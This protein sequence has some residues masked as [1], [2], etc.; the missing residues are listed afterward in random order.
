MSDANDTYGRLIRT[1]KEIALLGST[2]SVLHWDQETHLPTKGHE[3]RSNQVSLIAR[4]T[5]EQFTSP[6]VGEMLATA[7]SARMMD[8]DATV[9][10]RELRRL[11]DRATKIPAT[12]VEELSKTGVLAHQA[13]IEARKNS[14][15]PTFKPWLA[16][17]L[18]LKRQEAK[19]VGYKTAPYDALLDEFEPHETTENLKHVFES[20]RGPLVELV[21]KITS[22]G[23]TA[24]LEILERK[25]PAAA[26]EAV[27]R[28]ASKAIG[29]DFS[30]GRLDVSV[31]PFCSG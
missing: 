31:H 8:A 13:W 19:C 15:F 12:L 5:H 1:V 25:Y 29:F 20:L 17:L 27:A 23:K 16:K 24:P 26:Q 18:D 11:Y 4:M 10:L 14:S 9:N 21:G 2:A 22:S 30:A 7:E 6:Q 28:E 3:H